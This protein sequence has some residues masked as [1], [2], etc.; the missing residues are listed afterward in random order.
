MVLSIAKNK[1]TDMLR[2]RGHR[3]NVDE[4]AILD[5]VAS[6]TKGSDIYLQWRKHVFP[7]QLIELR[8][9]LYEFIATLPERQR[10]VAQCFVDN[11]ED[12][13]ERD[14]YRPLAEAVSAITGVMETVADVKN[15]WIGVNGAT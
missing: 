7:A 10:I 5:A 6:D 14:T 9:I 4:D 13:R 11:Y 12:F 3:I 1:A 8:E 15:V 2:E